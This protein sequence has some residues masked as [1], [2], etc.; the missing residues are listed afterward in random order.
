MEIGDQIEYKGWTIE[1]Q[2]DNFWCDDKAEWRWMLNITCP[3]GYAF[4]PCTDDSDG[5]HSVVQMGTKNGGIRLAKKIVDEEINFI[6]P[7]PNCHH[8][9]RV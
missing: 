8:I 4:D 5:W 1:R 7:C 9:K 2:T 6:E 3:Q